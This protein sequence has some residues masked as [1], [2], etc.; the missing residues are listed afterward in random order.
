MIPWPILR[1]VALVF[2]AAIVTIGLAAAL[3]GVGEPMGPAAGLALL[4]ALLLASLGLRWW[5]GR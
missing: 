4:I 3:S 5:S 1:I 2:V